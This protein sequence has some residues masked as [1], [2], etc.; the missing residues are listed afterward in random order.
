MRKHGIIVPPE[1]VG[2]SVKDAGKSIENNYLNEAVTVGLTDIPVGTVKNYINLSENEIAKLLYLRINR[3]RT[4]LQIW[5]LQECL[6][7]ARDLQAK[8]EKKYPEHFNCRD[9]TE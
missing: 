2:D 9:K 3:D 7:E 6:E 4:P 8:L 1:F 5:S